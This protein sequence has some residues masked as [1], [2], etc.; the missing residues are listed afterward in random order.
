MADFLFLK[1]LFDCE[2]ISIWYR[3]WIAASANDRF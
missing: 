1:E 2:L 3:I